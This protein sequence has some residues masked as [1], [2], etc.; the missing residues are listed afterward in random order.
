MWD[1]QCKIRPLGREFIVLTAYILKLRFF[2][3]MV[4]IYDGNIT[5]TLW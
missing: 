3:V 1:T 2:G 4:E 5:M